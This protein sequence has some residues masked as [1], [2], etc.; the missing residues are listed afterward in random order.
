MKEIEILQEFVNGFGKYK[1][2]AI[3]SE[4][5]I[6]VGDKQIHMD[7]VIFYGGIP[8][9]CVETKNDNVVDRR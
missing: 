1:D 9:A 3:K 8:I 6:R 2:F 4:F 7:A 5:P